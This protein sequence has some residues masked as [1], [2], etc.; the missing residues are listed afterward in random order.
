LNDRPTFL[1]GLSELV[2]SADDF[3]RD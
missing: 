2:N 3:W 1:R